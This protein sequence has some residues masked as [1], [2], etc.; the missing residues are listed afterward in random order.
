MFPVGRGALT[1]DSSDLP[2]GLGVGMD[3]EYMKLYKQILRKETNAAALGGCVNSSNR[4]SE[5]VFV[6]N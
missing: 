4:N 6:S 1:F 3:H 2:F 5:S